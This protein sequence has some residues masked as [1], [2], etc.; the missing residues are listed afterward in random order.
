MMHLLKLTLFDS[1]ESQLRWE[2]LERVEEALIIG[3]VNKI[4]IWN[5]KSLDSVDQESHKID[6]SEFDELANQIIL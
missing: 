3:M 5:P 6:S 4:E 2:D 1:D